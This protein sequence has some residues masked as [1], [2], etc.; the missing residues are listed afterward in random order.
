MDLANR[1]RSLQ[2]RC[3]T[4]FC[5]VRTCVRENPPPPRNPTR[6]PIWAWRTPITVSVDG[7]NLTLVP[8]VP[9]DAKSLRSPF[10]LRQKQ[11]SEFDSAPTFGRS[12]RGRGVSKICLDRPSLPLKPSGPTDLPN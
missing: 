4:R 11:C 8:Y 12:G 9:V 1:A 10:S 7:A 3:A 6:D 2:L 5:D